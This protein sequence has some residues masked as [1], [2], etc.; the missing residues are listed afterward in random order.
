MFIWKNC[1]YIFC[2]SSKCGIIGRGCWGIVHAGKWHVGEMPKFFP[3]SLYI[4][5]ID[6]CRKHDVTEIQKTRLTSISPT[7]GH[8]APS[9]SIL[10]ERT[11]EGAR[12]TGTGPR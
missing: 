9:E 2:Y 5:V 4:V 1:F 10:S 7:V 11:A 6:E 3:C 8:D 12:H